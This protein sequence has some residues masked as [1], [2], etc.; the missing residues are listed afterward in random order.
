MQC[1]H[2]NRN[3]PFL[4]PFSAH[5]N[6]TLKRTFEAHGAVA[7]DYYTAPTISPIL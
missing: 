1:G 5:N 2:F 3:S 6:P 4:L 7:G